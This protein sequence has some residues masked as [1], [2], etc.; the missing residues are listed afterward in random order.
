MHRDKVKRYLGE[1]ERGGIIEQVATQYINP[2]VAIVKKSGDIRICLDARELNKRMVND[3]AQSPSI[4]EIF[5]RIGSRRCFTTLDVTKAFWQIP[6]TEQSKKYTGFLFDNLTHIFRRMPFGIK[7]AGASFTRAMQLALGNDCDNFVITYLDDILIA[8]H[9]PEEHVRHVDQV[10][11]KL[12][13]VGFRL[14]KEKCEFMKAEIR[15]LKHTFNEI[16]AEINEE[17]KLAIKNFRR[18][19]NKHAVQSFLGLVNWER[20]FVRNLAGLTK[21]LEELLK[22]EKKFR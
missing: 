1:L 21:P 3:H 15:F 12:E 7:T 13:G 17:T 5:R 2:L 20:R 14:N 19:N 10:L 16:R 11:T 8:S 22:K 9:T 6:L 18:P 4:D